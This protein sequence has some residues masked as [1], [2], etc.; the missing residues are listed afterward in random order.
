M[1]GLDGGRDITKITCVLKEHWTSEGVE[2][3]KHS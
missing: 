1:L 3:W 2:M